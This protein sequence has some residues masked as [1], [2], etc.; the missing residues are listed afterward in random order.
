VIENLAFFSHN[1][2]ME[3]AQF[4][5]KHTVAAYIAAYNK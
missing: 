3:Y 5:W 4:D 1:A 2:S